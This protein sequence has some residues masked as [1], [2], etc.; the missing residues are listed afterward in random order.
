MRFLLVKGMWRIQISTFVLLVV[1]FMAFVPGHATPFENSDQ[2]VILNVRVTD[3]Q[4]KPVTDV[5]QDRFQVVE[6]GVPQTITLFSN[7][8]VPLTY[9]LVIDCSGSLRSQLPAVINAGMKILNSN[10]TDDEAFLI[11]FISSD[12]LFVEQELTSDKQ[13]LI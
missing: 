10:T 4:Q 11:R 1:G 12:K 9:G 5:P 7:K 8:Q 13:L 6:D 3:A 2:L